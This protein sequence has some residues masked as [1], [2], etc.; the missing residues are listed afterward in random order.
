MRMDDNDA[1]RPI[2]ALLR[3][4]EALEALNRRDGL[5]VSEVAASTGL[6]RTTAYRILETLCAGG[7]AARDETDDRYRP[8]LR[9]RGLAD[10]YVDERWITEAGREQLDALC[11]RIL[12]PM[13]LSTFG[14]GELRVRLSTDRISPL[15]LERYAPGA[16]L[17]L[18]TSSAG[19]MWLASVGAHERS[20]LLDLAAQ[21]GDVEDA[22]A[23]ITS[24]VER[25]HALDLRAA[26]SEASVSVPVRDSAGMVRAIVSMRYIR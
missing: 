17:A 25:G 4:L 22:R 10:G 9:V 21:D 1:V 14:G 20:A 13:M 6:P 15:A 12:W 18:T 26:S 2:R 8:T 19:L 16:V 23:A 11:R 7:Y 5:T 3:G 24:V